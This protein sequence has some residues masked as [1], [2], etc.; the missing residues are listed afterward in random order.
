MIVI[1]SS[2][3]I[4]PNRRPEL[5]AE[6]TAWLAATTRERDGASIYKY[7]TDPIDPSKVYST[8]GQL[9]PVVVQVR[10]RPPAAQHDPHSC[11]RPG[12]RRVRR[13]RPCRSG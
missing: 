10:L 7:L 12:A 9:R 4:D 2:M 5:H 11:R 6:L 1:F 13:A 3:T 8:P